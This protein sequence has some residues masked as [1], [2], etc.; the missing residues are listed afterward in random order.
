MVGGSVFIRVPFSPTFV[1]AD[2][3]VGIQLSK[4]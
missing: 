1:K 4:I 3:S 2:T